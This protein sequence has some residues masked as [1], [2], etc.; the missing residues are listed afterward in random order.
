MV[1]FTLVDGVTQYCCRR[2]TADDFT[3]IWFLLSVD[4]STLEG[5]CSCNNPARCWQY[6]KKRSIFTCM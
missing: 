4:F 2:L 1:L 6:K 3:H 5:L